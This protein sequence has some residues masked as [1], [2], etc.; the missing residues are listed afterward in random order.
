MTLLRAAL[1]PVPA[2]PAN[3]QQTTFIFAD[4]T[5]FGLGNI[6]VTLATGTFVGN[7]GDFA[8]TANGL[9]AIGSLAIGSCTLLVATSTFPVGQGLQVG[10]Q[11]VLDPCQ[12]DAIDRRL[13]VTNAIL[14]VA[15][16]IKP[17]GCHPSGYNAEPPDTAHPGH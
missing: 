12:I 16:D 8:L 15:T 11:I 1:V 5:I 7:V 10:D 3:L 4:G 13:I 6:P 9:V 2:T 17:A 14:R